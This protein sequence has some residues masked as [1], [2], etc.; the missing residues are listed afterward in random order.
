M[1]VGKVSFELCQQRQETSVA[2][3]QNWIIICNSDHI[4][5][6]IDEII[7]WLLESSIMTICCTSSIEIVEF[8]LLCCRYKKIDGPNY[9]ILQHTWLLLTWS[10]GWIGVLLPSWPP[11]ISI[12]LLLMTSLTFILVW[13]PDPVCHVTNGKWSSNFPSDTLLSTRYYEYIDRLLM[14]SIKTLVLSYTY[15]F[16]SWAAWMMTWANLSSRPY[17]RLTSA[18]ALFKNPKAR[19]I[20]I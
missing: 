11:S 3:E 2:L 14:I 20:W 16:T 10:L 17:W 6:T 7:D 15:K 9:L 4:I 19:M 18:A 5:T 1:A 13:V 12:D 8:W